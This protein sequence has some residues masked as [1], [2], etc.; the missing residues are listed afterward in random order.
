MPLVKR[1]DDDPDP[2][3]FPITGHLTT[4][5]E[6]ATF[7]ESFLND[8]AC[9]H[10]GTIH[11]L[12]PK[13]DRNAHGVRWTVGPENWAKVCAEGPD[14]KTDAFTVFHEDGDTIFFQDRTD[15]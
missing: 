6:A 14:M 15:P 8:L 10:G 7:Y 3:S 2:V 5:D 12:A 11:R 9:T 1:Y 13:P 4:A